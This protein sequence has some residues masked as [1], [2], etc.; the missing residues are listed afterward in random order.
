YLNRNNWSARIGVQFDPTDYFSSYTVASYN[1]VDENGGGTVLVAV[2]PARTYG[3]LLAPLLAA[4]QARGAYETALS[5]PTK[6]QRTSFSILNNSELT[7]SDEWSVKNIVSWS[8]VEGNTASDSDA[9]TLPISDLYGALPGRNNVDLRT[10]TE[11]LQ[12]RYSTDWMSLQTGLFYLKEDTPDDGLTFQTVNPMQA[13]LGIAT[14][15]IILP[16]SPF[17]FPVLSVQ[18]KAEVHGDSKAVYAQTNFNITSNLTA[19]AGVRWTWDTFGGHISSYLPASSFASFVANAPPA[20]LPAAL[21]TQALASDLCVYDAF[22]AVTLGQLPTAKYPNCSYPGFD[23]ESDGPTWQFGL[24]WKMDEDTLLY[25]VT[26]RGYKSGGTNPV[27]TILS[28]LGQNDPLFPFKPEEVT[29]LEFGMK[30][31]W[32]LADDVRLRTNA[33]AFYTWYNDIQVVQR[34]VFVGSDIATNAQKAHV[35]GFEFEGLLAFGDSFTL[36]ATYS[37]N[38][39]KYDEWQTLATPTLPSQN[40]SNTPFLYVPA[41]KFSLD[42]R[43]AIPIPAETGQLGFR[44]SYS[45]QDDQRVAADPQPFDTIPAYGLLNL[46][47]EWEEVMGGPIDIAVFGT[48]V[49]DE[50]YRV[51]SNAGY[52]T[53]GWVGTIYGEPAQY[54][55]S[56]RYRY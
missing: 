24:D 18:D 29:D 9:S 12:L 25:G 5:T 8:H 22:L 7:L 33:S 37:Y 26:R 34:Q 52:N 31:D 3:A 46:R 11:E 35:L 4:Q 49:T 44:A 56:L 27:V 47:L 39:A 1:D 32:R 54:G 38:E 36:G 10:F 30:R 42:G 53:S 21:Q 13:P 55:L 20:L 51:T 19:T 15:L 2:N 14:T 28:P 23:G 50:E 41:N 40:F 43:V 45:W 6:D 17:L 48:N 16:V